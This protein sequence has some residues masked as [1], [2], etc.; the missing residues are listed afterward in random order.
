MA[1]R[2]PLATGPEGAATDIEKRVSYLSS[3][4]CKL[5]GLKLVQNFHGQKILFVLGTTS[6]I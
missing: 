4:N 3:E 1:V 6:P 2:G 5:Y